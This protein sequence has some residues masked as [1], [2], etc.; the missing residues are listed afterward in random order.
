[1]LHNTDSF[2]TLRAMNVTLKTNLGQAPASRRAW[3]TL[4][5]LSAAFVGLLLAAG[6]GRAETHANL[7]AVN[8][9]GASA[10]S[11]SFP[12]TITG[13]LLCNPDEMLDS[14]PNFLPWDDGAN[15]YRMGGEWQVTFQAVA[16]GD[17]GGTTCWMGQNYGNQPWIHN[18][19]LSYANEAWVSEILLLNF[20]P[21]NLHQF[22]AGDLVE[23]TVRQALFYGGKRNINEGHEINPDYNFD[24]RLM[25]ANYGLPTP[26]VITLADV[27]S[28]DNNYIFD[29]TR[30]T[31]GEHYQGM[32]MRINNL[33]LTTTSGWNPTNTWGNRLC[34]ATD[35]TGRTFPLRHPRYSLGDAPTNQFD[36]IGIFSQESGSGSQGTNGYELFVQQVIPQDAPALAIAAKAAISWPVSGAAFD[37]EYSTDV[38]S[39]NWAVLTNA[40]VTIGGRNTVLD[41]L[42]NPQRYYRLR[43]TN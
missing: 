31:G 33:T 4:Q 12:F 21:A 2:F 3:R 5:S 27:K 8:A 42:T 26:E 19:D 10:W 1:M 37:L 41:V 20:D 32:R 11:G 38:N 36:V 13:V 39:T 40:P 23:I 34:T 15:Q 22:R 30:V 29:Q 24:I 28:A 35:G 16:P 7:Q 25:T 14:T 18:S 43:K 6:I 9:S 17:R